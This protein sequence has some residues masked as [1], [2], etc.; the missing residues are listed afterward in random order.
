MQ[1]MNL[2]AKPYAHQHKQWRAV[3]R[4]E[5]VGRS[6]RIGEMYNVAAKNANVKK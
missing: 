5:R 6:K 3:R 2:R 1:G 4:Q